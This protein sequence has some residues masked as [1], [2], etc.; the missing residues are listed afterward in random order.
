MSAPVKAGDVLAGKYRVDELL[1]E[2][3]MGVVVAAT[4]EQLRRRVAIK[5]LLP[6]FANH[7]E[8]SPRFMREARA[9]VRIQS[10]H[11]ARV[12]DVNTLPSGS[13]YMVMEFLEGSDL[14]QLIEKRGAMP[15]AD[16]VHWVVQACDAIAEA[17]SYGIVHRD[18]KPANLFLASQP[19]GGLTVKVLDFGISKNTMND[20]RDVSLTQTS[21]MMGSPLYMSPEQMRSTRDVDLRTDIWALG[22][23]LQELLTG[24]LPFEANSVPE[25]SAKIL[26]ED[27]EPI[28]RSDVP[29][30]MKQAIRVA[31]SKEVNDRYSSIADF[32]AAISQWAPTQARPNLERI[33]RVLTA[34]GVTHS[35]MK[36]PTSTGPGP[37]GAVTG[38]LQPVDLEKT[39]ADAEG[40]AR[41]SH[42]GTVAEWGNTQ[43][44]G[45]L[46]NGRS[47]VRM[48]AAVAA[49]LA[50]GTGGFYL[51]GAEAFGSKD[52]AS[53]AEVSSQKATEN[54]SAAA[55]LPGVDIEG[56]APVEST[57]IDNSAESPS[58]PRKQGLSEADAAPV[59]VS[60]TSESR[61]ASVETVTPEAASPAQPA[62]TKRV[63]R[64]RRVYKP[65]RASVKPPSE[66][67]VPA[68]ENSLRDKFGGRK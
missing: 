32:A 6:E 15:V 46:R 19:G 23:I 18:L 12:I 54:T 38:A 48:L 66:V 17:H 44:P 41:R 39:S 3:G 50:L 53:S 37:I 14:A 4:D 63:R 52:D 61:P 60:G 57:G 13:P 58:V 29:E 45:S 40:A 28:E 56:T 1:G 62:V 22:I 27:P 55:S 11:I 30:G 25:L 33:S 7:P 67:K 68:K 49:L 24:K 42:A 36:Q 35:G 43:G 16:A 2:G 10:E 8:A 59:G 34:A 21:S 51:L 64:P 65:R 20:A 9:A 26:L 31:L 47:K 5:F